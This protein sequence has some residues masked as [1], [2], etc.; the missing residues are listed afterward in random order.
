LQVNLVK[1]QFLVPSIKI[2][3]G[4]SPSQ[5]QLRYFRKDEEGLATEVLSQIQQSGLKNVQLTYVPNYEQSTAIRSKHLEVWFAAVKRQ[6]TTSKRTPT[7]DYGKGPT[8]PRS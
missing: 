2:T 1:Q 8:R 3:G 7:P 4:N 5:N 6:P